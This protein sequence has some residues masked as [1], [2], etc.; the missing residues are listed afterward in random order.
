MDEIRLYSRA[1]WAWGLEAQMR[2]LAE[3]CCELAVATLKS[4]RYDGDGPSE[5]HLAEEIA[6]VEIMLE[7]I[8]V[9]KSGSS[10]SVD[11]HKFRVLKLARLARR[12]DAAEAE[13]GE[14]VEA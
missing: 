4:I 14:E 1:L 10:L 11:I 2:Q 3:E 6:D 9:A 8:R 5:E 12:L 7:Q 13:P